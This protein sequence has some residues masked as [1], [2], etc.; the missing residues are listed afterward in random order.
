MTILMAWLMFII[1]WSLYYQSWK[2]EIVLDQWDVFQ[3]FAISA[4]F[5]IASAG[6]RIANVLEEKNRAEKKELEKKKKELEE[7]QRKIDEDVW[8]SR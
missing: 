6:R 1:G 4:F 5:F 7:E 2:G 3:Y 8:S